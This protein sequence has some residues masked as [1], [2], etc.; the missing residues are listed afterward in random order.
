MFWII[1]AALFFFFY[2]LP[3][4]IRL[5]IAII[6]QEWFWKLIKNIFSITLMVVLLIAIIAG[7]NSFINN[8]SEIGAY[9][10][11][12]ASFSIF[13][14]CKGTFFGSEDRKIENYDRDKKTIDMMD[15]VEKVHEQQQKNIEKGLTFDGKE[16]K[17]NHKKIK[18]PLIKFALLVLLISLVLFIYSYVEYGGF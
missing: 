9:I 14:F 3:I 10:A 11:L 2:I 15:E 4:L 17:D 18:K 6:V 8:E 13:Y 1:V 12:I 7:F 16:I 5:F